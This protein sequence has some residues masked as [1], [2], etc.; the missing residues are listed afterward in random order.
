MPEYVTL[1]GVLGQQ[2]HHKNGGAGSG[3][4]VGGGGTYV[5]SRVAIVDEVGKGRDYM[6]KKTQRSKE[7]GRQLF[8]SPRDNV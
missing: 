5:T 7:N 3:G 1:S 8:N 4:G 6:P 2:H